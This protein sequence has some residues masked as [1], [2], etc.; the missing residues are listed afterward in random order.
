MN[1]KSFFK[2]LF[3]YSPPIEYDFSLSDN[4]NNFEE[5]NNSRELQKEMKIFPALSVN[6]EYIKTRYNI[7]INSDIVF[8]EFTINARGKQY[9]AFIV[10]IDGMVDSQIMDQFKKEEIQNSTGDYWSVT[11]CC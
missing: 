7:L 1:I 8:R 4:V 3:A 11:P 6:I 5:I 9:N 2:I 10:Y